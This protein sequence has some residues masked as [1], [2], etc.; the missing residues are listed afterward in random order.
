VLTIKKVE[1][2]EKSL[3]TSLSRKGETQQALLKL[4]KSGS[5]SAVSYGYFV[6][7]LKDSKED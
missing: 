1:I 5:L 6:L 4:R 3:L 2:P 7:Q